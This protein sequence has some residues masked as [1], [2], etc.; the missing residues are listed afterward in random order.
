[1]T[2][3]VENARTE[4][5]KIRH[6]T[7]YKHLKESSESRNKMLNG[8]AREVLISSMFPSFS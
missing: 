3:E 5:I 7:C 4:K 8:I 1:M 2:K 6:N